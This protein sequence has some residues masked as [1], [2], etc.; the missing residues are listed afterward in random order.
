MTSSSLPTR[1]PKM[2]A[3]SRGIVRPARWILRGRR[4]RLEV[5]GLRS[6]SDRDNPDCPRPISVGAAGNPS[7]VE[8]EWSGVLRTV[9]AGMLAVPSRCAAH[10]PHLTAHEVAEI[11]AEVRA[12][13]TRLSTNQ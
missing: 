2:I 9:R 10:L 6:A 1:A 4:L 13:L 5:P 11:D 3:P 7:G 8:A 12:A